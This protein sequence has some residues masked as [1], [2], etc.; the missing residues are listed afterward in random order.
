[1]PLSA[2]EAC[3]QPARHGVG[4]AGIVEPQAVGQIG[5]ELGRQQAHLGQEVP[6]ALA[7]ELELARQASVEEHHG[8]GG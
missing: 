1:M 5:V 2:R 8:L 4:V 7:A 3:H 6:A